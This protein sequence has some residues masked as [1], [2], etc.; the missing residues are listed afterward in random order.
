VCRRMGT[1]TERLPDRW[2]LLPSLSDFVPPRERKS[3]ERQQRCE[4]HLEFCARARVDEV[5]VHQHGGATAPA[6]CQRTTR[7]FSSCAASL[8]MP[9]RA[10][11]MVDVIAFRLS[12]GS[13]GHARCARMFGNNLFHCQGPVPLVNFTPSRGSGRLPPPRL[14][15][16]AR[17]VPLLS[18][19][20]RFRANH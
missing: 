1:Q 20:H 10:T 18:E 19:W 11:Y 5:A 2:N 12:G 6:R 17:H 9:A 7:V 8:K 13:I 15:R 4:G 14:C 3:L 16:R